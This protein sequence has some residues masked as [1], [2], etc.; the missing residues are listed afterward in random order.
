[1]KP[2]TSCFSLLGFVTFCL[3]RMTLGESRK[4]LP[5][6]CQLMPDKGHC[7]SREDGVPV[8]R[9]YYDPAAAR[10]LP[11]NYSGCGGNKNRFNNRKK[12]LAVCGIPGI[13]P[14]CQLPR[15]KGPCNQELPRF[16][17]NTATRTCELFSYGGCEGFL[18]RFQTEEEC[19]KTCLSDGT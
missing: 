2:S 8:R 17:F 13:P 16:Y 15:K 1:M 11:F 7:S 19:L 12:C 6:L 4:I 18:N 9:Y 14:I 5:T 10:C 3:A